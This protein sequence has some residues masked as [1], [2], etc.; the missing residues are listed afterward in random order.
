MFIFFTWLC[1]FS[2]PRVSFEW[3]VDIKFSLLFLRVRWI[4]LCLPKQLLLC[5]LGL[6]ADWHI[7]SCCGHWGGD[8]V[9][10]SK[11]LAQK[12]KVGWT[13]RSSSVFPL[14]LPLTFSLNIA[15]MQGALWWVQ[16]KLYHRRGLTASCNTTWYIKMHPC[17]GLSCRQASKTSHCT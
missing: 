15:K 17:L 1:N 10:S 11:C 2:G 16:H 4:N 9:V 12:D 5:L 8:W 13:Y 3:S 14:V 6:C 7:F